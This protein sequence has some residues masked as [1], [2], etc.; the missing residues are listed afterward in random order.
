MGVLSWLLG[1]GTSKVIEATGTAVQKVYR[2]VKGDKAEVEAAIADEQLATLASH[3]AEFAERGTRT[4]LDSV[5][6][7]INRL[8]RPMI[9][10]WA[11]SFLV[12]PYFAPLDF[13]EYVLALQM[14]PEEIWTIILS[15]F[16][17]FLGSRIISSDI[18]KPKLT[19]EEKN[20]AIEIIREREKVILENRTPLIVE[21]APTRKPPPPPWAAEQILDKP[22]IPVFKPD[23]EKTPEIIK[24]RPVDIDKMI[25]E[26]LKREG[27]F[28]NDPSD[29][30]GATNHGITIATLS[31]WREK[32]CTVDDVKALT[33]DEAADIYRA[34]FYF[35]PGIDS[36]PTSL[37]GHVMDCCV[38]MG[39]RQGIKLLQRALNALGATIKED[40]IVGPL[41]RAG[42]NDYMARD[43]HNK[44]VDVR[45][46]F[47][48][49]L[50]V[51]KPQNKKFLNGWKKR[52]NS[53]RVA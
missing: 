34:E 23:L 45:I 1:T 39:P 51:R 28:V 7:F 50:A 14:I 37:Q 12:I 19:L 42:C 4:K 18:R 32:E 40:G 17:F 44:L 2:T 36:L 22:K 10:F 47:Y 6:D 53:F 20:A 27:G 30:G 41:T 8:P 21:V 46:K 33:K 48:E 35:L 9:V 31:A 16:A 15:V 13:L 24:G 49:D 29:A 43:I 25:L 11:L 26:L 5:I 52:A 38:N 3:A